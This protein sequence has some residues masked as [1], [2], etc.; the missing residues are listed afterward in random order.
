M[1][2]PHRAGSGAPE[3][4][5]KIRDVRLETPAADGE[6]LAVLKFHALN[7]GWRKVTEIVFTIS[8]VEPPRTASPRAEPRV[9]AGPF[10]VRGDVTLEPGDTADFEVVLRHLSHD[11]RCAAK[12][13]VV[14][15]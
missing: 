7:D 6:S 13:R 12:L 14:S 8:I 1:D 3:S 10:R 5:V 15:P 9:I 2:V 4:P 11:C